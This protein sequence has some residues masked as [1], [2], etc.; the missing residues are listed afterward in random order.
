MPMT[1]GTTARTNGRDNDG[2]DPNRHGRSRSPLH[3][4]RYRSRDRGGSHVTVTKTTTRIV[5][6]AETEQTAAVAAAVGVGAGLGA[7]RHRA[8]EVVDAQTNKDEVDP[9]A[10]KEGDKLKS[11]TPLNNRGTDPSMR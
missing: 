6:E 8:E 3:R 7:V 11:T 9:S 4:D 1:I 2:Q 10:E 5:V